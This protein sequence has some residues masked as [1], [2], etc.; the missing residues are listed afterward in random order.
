MMEDGRMV[1]GFPAAQLEARM[2]FLHDTL[3]V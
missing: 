3:G 2:D 1:D